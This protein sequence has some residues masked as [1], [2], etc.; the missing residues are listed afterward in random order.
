MALPSAMA[1]GA[2]ESAKTLAL[3]FRGLAGE[4]NI[5]RAKTLFPSLL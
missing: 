3:I 2:Y 1:T 5:Y 4:L